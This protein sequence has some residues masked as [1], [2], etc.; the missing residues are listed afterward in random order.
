MLGR[1]AEEIVLDI[2][3]NWKR[4][5]LIQAGVD[6]VVAVTARID[7]LKSW[8]EMRKRLES[9]AVIRT[10]DLRLISKTEARMNIYFTGVPEQ[11]ALAMEQADLGLLSAGSHWVL[12]SEATR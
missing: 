6:N 8:L 10:I 11:L 9:V 4:D 5:N 12:T 7:G 3:D 2:E 1:A